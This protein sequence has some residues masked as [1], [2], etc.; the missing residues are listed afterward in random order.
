MFASSALAASPSYSLFGDA[1][2]VTPGNASAH[3]V[4]FRSASAVP[5]GYGGVDFVTS[6]PLTVNSLNILSTDFKLV[7]G[8]CAGGAPRFALATSQGN[9]F[10]YLG[11]APNYTCVNGVWQS[12]TNLFDPTDLIDTS[13]LPGGNFYDTVAHAKILFGSL[14]ITDFALVTDSSWVAGNDP[15]TVQADNVMINS[16]LYTFEPNVP[17]NKD[18]CKDGGYKN[19]TDQNFQ[20]FKNQGQ[21]E[22]FVKDNQK[23]DKDKE[24][25]SD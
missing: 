3:A 16:D 8:T 9:I 10:V 5:P 14:A 21:C 18:Q 11:T 24:D 23:K 1:A 7:T 17:T 15:Q 22:K 12:S 13:Q 19:F 2:I 25:H 6:S 20:P 4:Q